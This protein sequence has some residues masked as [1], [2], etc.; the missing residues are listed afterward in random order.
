MNWKATLWAW[1]AA[2]VGAFLVTW[3]QQAENLK[4]FSDLV[5]FQFVTK[6]VGTLVV[7]GGLGNLLA[8]KTFRP[9]DARTRDEDSSVPPISLP[10]SL[11]LFED[12]K[13]GK[14]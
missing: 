3:W 11:N 8:H 14:K 7:Q 13:R 10:V 5:E 1:G 9:K 12:D 6:Y 4:G 2:G